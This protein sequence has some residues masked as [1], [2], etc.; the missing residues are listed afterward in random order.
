MPKVAAAFHA[1]L[2]PSPLCPMLHAEDEN[3]AYFQRMAKR[4]LEFSSV[5]IPFNVEA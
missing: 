3:L 4:R 2:M 1:A 5:S